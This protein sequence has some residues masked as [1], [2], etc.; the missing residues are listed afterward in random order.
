[1]YLPHLY[2]IP[3]TLHPTLRPL[4]L[5]PE[6]PSPHPT[7]PC[8]HF[9]LFSSYSYDWDQLKAGVSQK[10]LCPGSLS[11][12]AL[13]FLSLVAW[14]PP[15]RGVISAFS[16][17]ITRI[18]RCFRVVDGPPKTLPGSNP[19]ALFLYTGTGP[20]RSTHQQYVETCIWRNLTRP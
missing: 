4:Y 9:I 18:I 13:Y 1:M 3:N 17:P 6:L 11:W 14:N 8:L 5:Y 20:L 7:N 16:N 2:T 15:H 10:R 19:C 12:L